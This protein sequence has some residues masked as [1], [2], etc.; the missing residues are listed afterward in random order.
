MNYY[1]VYEA[2]RNF[3]SKVGGFFRTGQIISEEVYNQ[4]DYSDRFN[5]VVHWKQNNCGG[6]LNKLNSLK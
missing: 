3:T 1:K 4:L 5:F 2:T 6:R